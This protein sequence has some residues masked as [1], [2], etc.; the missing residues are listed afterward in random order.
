MA[1]LMNNQNPVLNQMLISNYITEVISNELVKTMY[2][3]VQTLIQSTPEMEKHKILAPFWSFKSFESFNNA[4]LKIPFD[5]KTH[6][7]I[8]DYIQDKQRF[9]SAVSIVLRVL[10]TNKLLVLEASNAIF[11]LIPQNLFSDSVVLEAPLTDPQAIFDAFGISENELM[12]T[13]DRIRQTHVEACAII[14]RE[15]L[16]RN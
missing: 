11:A 8:W 7:R 16:L 4:I 10:Q 2:E 15:A 3:N 1:L 5:P 14:T 6:N 13:L 12:Q 9:L